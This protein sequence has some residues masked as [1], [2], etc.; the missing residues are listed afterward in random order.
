MSA[1][2]TPNIISAAEDVSGVAAMIRPQFGSNA[3]AIAVERVAFSKK[4]TAL[5]ATIED[6][7]M[8]KTIGEME[9]TYEACAN[10]GGDWELTELAAA[11]VE[12]L[13]ASGMPMSVWQEAG[14]VRD[15]VANRSA[16]NT[17]MLLALEQTKKSHHQ[18]PHRRPARQ[19]SRRI[20]RR[21]NH[22]QRLQIKTSPLL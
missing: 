14:L 22:H 11:L 3:E 4:L 16:A 1:E 19:T 13:G 6:N 15:A 2:K 21:R 7:A 9:D 18:S 17:A 12:N 8:L 5:F 20:H 10:A